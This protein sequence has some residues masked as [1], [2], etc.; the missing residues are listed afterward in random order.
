MEE[1]NDVLGQLGNMVP[2][3]GQEKAVTLGP[4]LVTD[5]RLT[6]RQLMELTGLA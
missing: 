3:L 6:M 5:L 1:K 2:H 4:E